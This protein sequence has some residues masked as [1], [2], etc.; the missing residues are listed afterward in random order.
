MSARWVFYVLLA[1]THCC[2]VRVLTSQS[3]TSFPVQLRGAASP[4]YFLLELP[5]KDSTVLLDH[6]GFVRASWPGRTPKLQPD[7]SVTVYSTDGY[8][9]L[10]SREGDSIGRLSADP[11]RTDFHDITLL[12]NGRYLSLGRSERTVDLSE[13]IAGASESAEVL[14]AVI[15]EKGLD[16]TVH[17]EWKSLDHLSVS[18]STLSDDLLRNKRVNY[19]HANS[20]I[21]DTDGHILVSSRNLSQIIKVS[22]TTGEVLWRLGGS[23]SKGN[24]FRWLND[25]IAGFVG[26]SQQ[27]SITRTKNGD[28][29]LFDN[30][31]HRQRPYSRAIILRI[32]ESA[33]SVERVWQYVHPD[34]VFAETMGSAVELP[35]GNILIGWG[36]N[37]GG[38]VFTEVRR[39]GVVTAELRA[40]VEFGSSYRV[41]KSSF[42]APYFVGTVPATGQYVQSDS[43]G[44]SLRLLPSSV[45]AHVV[46][47]RHVDVRSFGSQPE[48]LP[49]RVAPVR[50]TVRSVRPLLGI[51]QMKFLRRVIPT[52]IDA[53]RI[54]VYHRPQ[55]GTGTWRRLPGRWLAASDEF[56]IDTILSGEFIA[57]VEECLIP[58]LR[59]PIIGEPRVS[60]PVAFSWSDALNDQGY[61]LQ[62]SMDSL[63]LSNSIVVDTVSTSSQTLLR[64]GLPGGA[65]FFWRVSSIRNQGEKA[66]S[67]TGYFTTRL[68]PPT[69][70]RPGA[71]TPQSQSEPWPV[72]FSWDRATSDQ[73][74]EVAVWSGGDTTSANPPVYST[75]TTEN[76]ISNLPPV[77]SR[78]QFFWSV[79]SIR[80]GDTSA[81][82]PRYSFTTSIEHPLRLYP[83]QTVVNIDPNVALVFWSAVPGA[84]GYLLRCNDVSGSTILE[85][86]VIDTLFALPTFTANAPVRFQVSAFDGNGSSRPITSD[87]L[88]FAVSASVSA[89]I[90]VSPWHTDT[91]QPNAPQFTWFASA[92]E[93]CELIIAT[94]SAMSDVVYR[95]LSPES[96]HSLPSSL[97]LPYGSYYWTVLSNRE[98][99]TD[100]PSEVRSFAY[101]PSSRPR[102]MQA[103]APRDGA[104][105][106]PVQGNV[107]FRSD[108]RCD[109]YRLQIFDSTGTRV[110]ISSSRD[111]TI[112]YAGLRQAATYRW[113]VVGES[114]SNIVDTSALYTFRTFDPSV[115]VATTSHER[116]GP[117]VYAGRTS[118]TVV[119]EGAQPE[120]YVRLYDVVGRQI[121]REQRVINGVPIQAVRGAVY[122]VISHGQSAV[123][124]LV[125]VPE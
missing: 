38:A 68:L 110:Y 29:L 22:R 98:G 85:R 112:G 124:H 83:E 89:P 70:I 24:M 45:D 66:W 23:S 125:Y 21:L 90:L 31:N 69:N 117:I 97:V 77:T 39:D 95:S 36:N 101:S 12:S 46:V 55:E 123:R 118:A 19:F 37:Q 30:G 10:Y 54:F 106:V 51:G 59:S 109:E 100:T 79:R 121:G 87:V 32:N 47:E 74:W 108:S 34:S 9:A 49:C 48:P 41:D 86:E 3:A 71:T 13:E 93:H 18:Q 75:H 58:E 88:S 102:P 122:V 57:G 53:Q 113:H 72:L 40:G 84:S 5:S 35:D 17:F 78:T 4:G 20:V 105:Q 80:S 2:T 92:P 76:A 7:G 62:V 14:E 50:W 119:V 107:V 52:S 26:F 33:R 61:R 63:F 1:L 43:V 25:T 82:S 120:S 99:G 91:L 60:Q 103:V 111:T 104:H 114:A 8:Y 67:A 64:R 44:I 73:S 42:V 15:L 94:D 96:A 65:Q 115:S 27:H 6:G 81:W 16:G 28:L 56:E 11:Y 116:F